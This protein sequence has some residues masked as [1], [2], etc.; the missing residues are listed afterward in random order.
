VP[1]KLTG[2]YPVFFGGRNLNAMIL[3]A[4]K[5]EA[6]NSIQGSAIVSDLEEMIQ[7]LVFRK[8]LVFLFLFLNKA[9]SISLIGGCVL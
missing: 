4:T 7:V 9:S 6:R 8:S 3:M 5:V 1:V 2:A